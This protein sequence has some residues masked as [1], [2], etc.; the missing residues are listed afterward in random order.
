MRHERKKYLEEKESQKKTKVY[1]SIFIKYYV[2]TGL[3]LK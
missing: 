3:V 2:Y 1:I